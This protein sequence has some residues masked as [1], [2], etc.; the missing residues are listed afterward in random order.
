MS[1]PLERADAVVGGLSGG[2]A[3]VR[4]CFQPMPEEPKD[5]DD[6]KVVDRRRF[7]SA[8]ERRPG[9]ELRPEP[10]PG[11]AAAAPS[12]APAAPR[13]ETAEERTAREAYDGQR[14]PRDYKVDFESLVMSLST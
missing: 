8:G 7:T 4:L 6:V 11:P 2:R 10:P 12:P 3:D 13:A 9:A 1:A 5:S 14:P